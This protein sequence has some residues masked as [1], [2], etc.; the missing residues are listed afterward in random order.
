[1]ALDLEAEC[2]RDGGRVIRSEQKEEM[3]VLFVYPEDL[4]EAVSTFVSYLWKRYQIFVQDY[5]NYELTVGCGPA[6]GSPEQLPRALR[7]ACQALNLR[8]LYGTN[9]Q[10]ELTDCIP[11]VLSFQETFYGGMREM[12]ASLEA[13]DY[14]RFRGLVV[15]YFDSV[16]N[17]RRAIPE[18]LFEGLDAVAQ[19]LRETYATASETDVEQV[20]Q[21][22]RL[23]G[24]YEQL[25]AELLRLVKQRMDTSYEEKRFQEE[26]P[27]RIAK[28]YI[29]ENFAGNVSLEGA[30]D[31]AGLNPNYFSVLFKKITGQNFSEYLTDCRMEE[32]KKLLR[33]TTKNL[34]EVGMAV[35]YKDAK[36]FSRLFTRTVGL[37]PNEYRKLYS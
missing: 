37:K 5:G 2:A 25:K 15:T 6:V 34:A 30:A 11:K 1:M 16:K 9:R 13:F 24:T 3:T 17:D 12:A 7:A 31:H 23:A 27:I 33:T 35:G 4:S 32:A 19:L 36:Y 14:E 29:E 21:R 8:F 20:R 22:P 10:L 18:N 26:Q 28:R